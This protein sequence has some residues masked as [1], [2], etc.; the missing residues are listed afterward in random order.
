MHYRYYIIFSTF[1]LLLGACTSAQE[2]ED[3]TATAVSPTTAPLQEAPAALPTLLPTATAQV[4]PDPVETS[5]PAPK[6]APSRAEDASYPAPPTPLPPPEA[7]PG[8]FVWIT[9]PSGLQCEDGALPGFETLENAVSSL[10]SVGIKVAVADEVDLVVATVCGGPA[11]K[12][13]RAQI[14]NDHLQNAISIGWAEAIQ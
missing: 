5:Y 14:G 3:N 2:V 4:E 10:T 8:G 9:H 13:Y 1:L 7:Y 12:H 6:Q 11:S